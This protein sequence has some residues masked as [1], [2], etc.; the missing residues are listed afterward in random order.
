MLPTN[1]VTYYSMVFA[2]LTVCRPRPRPS[3]RPVRWITHL[4]ASISRFLLELYSLFLPFLKSSLW[5]PLSEILSLFLDAP[6]K[7]YFCLDNS[8][9]NFCVDFWAYYRWSSWSWSWNGIPTRYPT[10]F[11]RIKPVAQRHQMVSS[12]LA[13]LIKLNYSFPICWIWVFFVEAGQRPR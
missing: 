13:L 12:S 3:P 11:H 6:Y 7:A 5:N 1:R 10:G 2:H 9:V 8:S 4:K